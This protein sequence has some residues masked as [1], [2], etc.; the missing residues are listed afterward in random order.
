MAFSP[1]QKLAYNSYRSLMEDYDM[2]EVQAHRVF[3]HITGLKRIPLFGDLDD[4]EAEVLAR[5]LTPDAIETGVARAGQ[6]SGVCLVCGKELTDPESVHRGTGPVCAGK[7]TRG[8]VRRK[9][10]KQPL[11]GL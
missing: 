3:K 2:S 9:A 1:N 7:V 11:Y 5:K 8:T 4:S 6:E 10:D